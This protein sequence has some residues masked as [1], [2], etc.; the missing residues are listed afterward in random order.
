M[1]KT[2]IKDN[3]RNIRKQ[4]VSFISIIVIAMLGVAIFLGLDYSAAGMTRNGS[5][6]FNAQNFRDI[7]MVSTLLF[8]QSD[9]DDI[10]ST[11][12][13]ADAEAVWQ[14]SAKSSSGGDRRDVNVISLTE[15]INLP[16]LSEGRLT[17][18]E[19]E[20]AAEK[21]LAEE[22]G[23]TVGSE[24]LLQDAAGEKLQYLNGER[25][26]LVGIADHPDHGNIL[27]T[28]TCYVIVTPGT[29][30]RQALDDCCMKV[31]VSI[32]KE[33]GIDRYSEEYTQAVAVVQERLEALAVGATVRR[34]GE[35]HEQYRQQIDEGQRKLD[36]AEAELQT[37]RGE[38]DDGWTALAEGEQELSDAKAQLDDAKKELDDAWA[39]LEDGRVQ[40]EEANGKLAWAKSELQ[41]A[42]AALAEAKAPLDSAK[43]QLKSG[44]EALEDAKARIRNGIRSGVESFLGDASGSIS[45]AGRSGVNVDSAG[46]TAMTFPIANGFSI[47]LH[48]SLGQ[49]VNSFVYSE[50]ITDQMLL[51]AYID[52][53]GTE[54]G[55]DAGTARADLAAAAVSA[56][57][58]YGGDY[59]A[60]QSACA[61]WDEG[62]AKYISGLS[63][64]NAGHAEYEAKLAEYQEGLHWYN[65]NI[66]VYRK[67]L[68]QYD[69]GKKAYEQGL[70]DY[71]AGVKELEENREKLTDGEAEYEQGLAEY[72]EEEQRLAKARAD[73]DEIAPCRWMILD[74]GGNPG[75][76]QIRMTGDNLLSLKGTFALLFLLIGALV[77][78][79]TVSKIVDEQRTQ[80]GTTKA[81]GFFNREIFAKYLSFGVTATV[82]GAALGILAAR[83]FMERIALGGYDVFY[84]FDLSKPAVTAGAS[85]AALLAA[86]A[87]ALIAVWAACYRL[88][89][90]PAM[91]LM[92]ARIPEGA[93]KA[94]AGRKHALSLYS[95]LILLN[96]RSDIRRVLVTVVSVAGCC[97]LIVIG[98]TL[99]SGMMGSIDRQY[100]EITDYDWRVSFVRE[101]SEQ[102]QEEIEAALQE[103]GADFVPLQF[104]NITYRISDMQIAEL[105]VCDVDDVQACCHLRDWKSGEVMTATDDGI[106][107]P[108]RVAEIYGLDV[109][110]EFEIA[111]GGITSATVRVA[112][113]FEYFVGRPML[114]SPACYEEVFGAPWEPNTFFVRLNGA[115]ET[116]LSAALR[117]VPGFFGVTRSDESMA[118]FE[119]STSVINGLV[120]LFIFMGAVM[121]GVVQLNLTNMYVLQKKRELTI[122]R[123]NGF[124]TR[125]TVSYL[126]RE[127]YVTTGLGILLGL[128]IGSWIAYYI[129]RSLEQPFAQ[130][131]RSIS[132]PAWIVGAALTVLFTVLVN[133]IALQPVKN[134]RL[135]DIA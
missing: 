47:D 19:T 90:T 120:L 54:E 39:E 82:L 124:T 75:Y 36:D 24:I 122:M 118:V 76:V 115:D 9:L 77:I 61:Q 91:R 78:F 27:V 31:E 26:T 7:E 46:A 20:C 55:F 53:T 102:A 4:K 59:S 88:L 81:L 58:A 22:M 134:L 129:L 67:G 96:I 131:V 80:V 33:T 35:I 11:E 117:S 71:E 48:Q 65:V 10:R 29:F 40:L 56:A 2:Q 15:R 60:L 113:V 104:A 95:R 92:Q 87:L 42:E 6:F 86:A 110:S 21:K 94:A 1:K 105:Y 73:L 133:F 109:G 100:G 126:L 135:T 79:A 97:A 64:Y 121:A 5:A 74:G 57:G 70:A 83:F 13:V 49:I 72:R 85:L 93:K 123:V 99:R 50:M 17:E 12:G 66:S 69:E 62:H 41:K 68:E 28:D 18:T 63:A 37:A 112:G 98:V 128:G 89:R 127:T 116:A 44:W 111:L 84:V 8:T 108:R 34:D 130:F 114:M 125:E 107:I 106:L 103:A 43:A 38:L 3:L 45:W 23:W 132:V 14:V 25:F 32:E 51:D 52:Q 101:G 119:S 30:D 16:L